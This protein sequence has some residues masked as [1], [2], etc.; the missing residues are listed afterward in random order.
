MTSRH[1]HPDNDDIV[2]DVISGIEDVQ[3][4]QL[5]CNSGEH[6]A[7]CKYFILDLLYKECRLLSTDLFNF[8]DDFT[9]GIETDF[10]ECE[11][12]FH[13]ENEEKSCLVWVYNI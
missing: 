4:C 5:E 10:N 2:I 13:D 12:V 8:C 1:C 3:A 7:T 9:G 6:K 11:S